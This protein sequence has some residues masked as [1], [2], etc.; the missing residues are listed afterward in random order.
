[1]AYQSTKL[2]LDQILQTVEA[3]GPI[4]KS[5]LGKRILDAW[6]IARMG[7]RLQKRFEE[8]LELADIKTTVEINGEECLWKKDQVPDN[9]LD[10]RISGEND[11][12]RSI[13]E[14]PLIEVINGL[15]TLLRQMISLPQEDLIREGAKEFGFARAGSQVREKITLAIQVM[16]HQNRAVEVEGRVKLTVG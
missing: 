14:I 11:F 6:G 13:E 2:Q 7:G 15:T 9:Y 12:K 3:E 5:L 16:I 1:M 8:L 4:L 10:Y